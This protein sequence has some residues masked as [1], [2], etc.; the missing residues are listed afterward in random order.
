MLH[1]K[2]FMLWLLLGMCG[3]A[4][5]TY[6]ALT[7]PAQQLIPIKIG[8]PTGMLHKPQYMITFGKPLREYSRCPEEDSPTRLIL[9]LDIGHTPQGGPAY[10]FQIIYMG[11]PRYFTYRGWL[12]FD[13]LPR[14]K[15]IP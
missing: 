15:Q 14:Y 2:R 1:I 12:A 10:L 13:P 9:M 11:W 8:P 6:G 3:S 4:L 7:W 5:A